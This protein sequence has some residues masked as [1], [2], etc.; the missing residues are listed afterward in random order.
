[1]KKCRTQPDLNQDW[2]RWSH[3]KTTYFDPLSPAEIWLYFRK[4][5]SLKVIC[6]MPT[7]LL[8]AHGQQLLLAV[9]YWQPVM[10]HLSTAVL[11][12]DMHLTD[13]NK[14]LWSNFGRMKSH[15]K[16]QS[17]R[18]CYLVKIS[19]IDNDGLATEAISSARKYGITQLAGW[20]WYFVTLTNVGLKMIS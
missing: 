12:I 9:P 5:L 19:Q 14:V 1:M 4:K 7:G 16:Q 2:T 15:S 20:M 3:L 11:I 18:G 10:S 6:N 17:Y 13:T 8:Q